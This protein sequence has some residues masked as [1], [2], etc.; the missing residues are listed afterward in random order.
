MLIISET[1][2][3]ILTNFFIIVVAEV[4]VNISQ[5]A[6]LML[7]NARAPHIYCALLELTKTHNYNL[8]VQ[9][10]HQIFQLAT[11]VSYREA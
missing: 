5:E 9:S 7:W 1:T 2:Q 6:Q 4:Y 8:P 11:L 10:I 3:H